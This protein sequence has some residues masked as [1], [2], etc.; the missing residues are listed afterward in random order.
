MY[1]HDLYYIPRSQSKEYDELYGEDPMKSFQSAHVLEMYIKNVEGFEGE[2][3]IASQFGLEIRDQ[4]TFQVAIRRFEEL[5]AENAGLAAIGITR[6]REGD[7]IFLDFVR[8]D[9]K[10]PGSA[11]MFFEIMYVDHEA[12]FYQ[13]GSLQTYDLR[14]EAF[15]YS[16][17]TFST[18]VNA[19]DVAFANGY[20]SYV[21]TGNTPP[22][23]V[24][25]NTRI[26][27]EADL[28]LDFSEDSPFGEFGGE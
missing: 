14:C 27:A 26:E 24:A 19:I 21:T 11:G 8:P 4:T 28:I 20:S 18:G 12:I 13:L 3:N 15:R 25:D 6:P 23:G 2:G 9:P 16:N 5:I 1:G 10:F 7:L 22:S 17:E